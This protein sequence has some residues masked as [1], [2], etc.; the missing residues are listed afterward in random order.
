MGNCQPRHA[1][2]H[3]QD[4]DEEQERKQI[5]EAIILHEQLTGSKPVGWY[6]GRTSPNTLKL[7]AERE[8]S[9]IAPILMLTTCLTTIAITASRY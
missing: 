4:M 1:L 6:T 9:Y 3:Y 8:I 5:D 2:V 7:I